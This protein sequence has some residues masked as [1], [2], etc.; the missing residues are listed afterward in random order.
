MLAALVHVCVKAL[1]KKGG[2]RFHMDT[3]HG[4][5][6]ASADEGPKVRV[7]L[8]FRVWGLGFRV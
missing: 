8:A 6:W 4:H 7:Q 5:F 2:P 1:P 3:T